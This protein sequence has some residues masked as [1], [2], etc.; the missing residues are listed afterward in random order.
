MA[1]LRGWLKHTSLERLLGE[2][3]QYANMTRAVRHGPL[4]FAMHELSQV[5]NIY[6]RSPGQQTFAV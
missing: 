2:I 6:P 4:W 1:H 3:P 5:L